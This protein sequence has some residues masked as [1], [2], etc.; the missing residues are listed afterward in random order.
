MAETTPATSTQEPA[1]PDYDE[2]FDKLDAILDKRQDGLAKS[3]LKDNGID[4]S[5]IADIFK[6]LC[7]RNTVLCRWGISSGLSSL[8]GQPYGVLCSCR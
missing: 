1:T 5:E 2:I 7:I 3:A 8:A 6:G 4:E